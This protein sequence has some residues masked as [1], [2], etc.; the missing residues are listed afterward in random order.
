MYEAIEKVKP[1]IIFVHNLQFFDISKIVKYAKK[2][3]VK[4]YADNHADFSNS[5]RSKA[6]VDRKSVV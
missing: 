3:S 4:I 1:E 5:A 2:H 6:A